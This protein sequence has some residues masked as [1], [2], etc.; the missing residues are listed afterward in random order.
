M[1]V[2]PAPATAAL[3][4]DSDSSLDDEPIN[5]HPKLKKPINTV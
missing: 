5:E 3:A 2:T 1:P 4:N